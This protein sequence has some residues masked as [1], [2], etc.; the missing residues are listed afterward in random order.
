M[1]DYCLVRDIVREGIHLFQSVYT[2]RAMKSLLQQRLSGAVQT[3]T[4]S[5]AKK[6]SFL[7][8]GYALARC[9]VIQ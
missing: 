6:I 4:T 2:G 3:Q 8:S 7:Y 9:T 5:F 1:S